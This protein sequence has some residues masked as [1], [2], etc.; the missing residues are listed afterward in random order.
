MG[1][2]LYSEKRDLILKAREAMLSA[3]QIFNNP[4]ITF[5][6]ES[7]IVLSVIAWTY[8]LHAHYRSLRIEYRYFKKKGA[9]KRFDHNSDGSYRYWELRTCIVSDKCPLDKDTKNNL[10]FLIGLRNQIEHKKASGLDSYLSARYQ[11]C[12]LNFNQYLKKLHGE[13]YGLDESLALSLQFAELDQSQA[14]L[15]KDKENLIPKDVISYISTFDSRLSNTEIESARF[16]Y[17]LLFVKVLAKRKGQADRVIEFIDP[18]SE[19]AKN[20]SKEYWV[21]EETEKP[22]LSATR[23]VRTVR[24]AGYVG[25]GMHQHT[26]FWKKHDGKNP[27]KGFG[28]LVE[29]TWYW[30]RH[31]PTFIISELEKGKLAQKPGAQG[32]PTVPT[33]P[34]DV[35]AVVAAASTQTK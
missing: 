3:V 2:S 14:K 9:R 8:L 21:K 10:E 29:K 33:S 26:L 31:W 12:A 15:I 23:V 24:A 1:R 30:Y 25:F 16:A 6:T 7:F 32:R 18:K 22:K 34:A 11:A 4:L 13:R 28:T 17:R 27:A 5:K 35:A 19:L 20:I